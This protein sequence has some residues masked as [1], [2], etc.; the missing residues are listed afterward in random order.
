MLNLFRKVQMMTRKRSNWSTITKM[1]NLCS[2]FNG[3][4]LVDITN[5]FEALVGNF[6]GNLRFQF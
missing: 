2:A 6:E 3:N 4:S 1:F 5:L